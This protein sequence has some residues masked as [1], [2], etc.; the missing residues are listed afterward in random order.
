MTDIN[1]QALLQRRAP[2]K[3][4]NL[5]ALRTARRVQAYTLSL[6]CLNDAVARWPDLAKPSEDEWTK[7]IAIYKIA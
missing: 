1:L 4:R 6:R 2:G 7:F 5:A 3:R